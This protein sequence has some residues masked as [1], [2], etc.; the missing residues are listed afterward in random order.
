MFSLFS[1]NG[2]A[3]SN[4]TGEQS[5][6]YII[7]SIFTGGEVKFSYINKIKNGD[8]S[9]KLILKVNLFSY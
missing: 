3:Q 1:I 9:L 7:T 5:F 4:F 2:H 6:V 8:L